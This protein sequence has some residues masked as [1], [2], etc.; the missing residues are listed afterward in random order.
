MVKGLAIVT[1]VADVHGA[2]AET[3]FP[4]LLNCAQSPDGAAPPP[5]HRFDPST[6][7]VFV[8]VHPYKFCPAVAAVL[9]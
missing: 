9:K 8:A 5:N 4:E 7:H 6:V 3:I 2:P 1:V